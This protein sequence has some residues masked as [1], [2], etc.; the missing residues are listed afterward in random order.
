MSALHWTAVSHGALH[1]AW[2]HSSKPK[3]AIRPVAGTRRLTCFRRLHLAMAQSARPRTPSGASCRPRVLDRT[4]PPPSSQPARA[5]HA[6]PGSGL[7]GPAPLSR[8]LIGAEPA[9]PCP[10]RRGLLCD[11][12]CAR[13]W[14][15]RPAPPPARAVVRLGR[16]ASELVRSKG[17]R[18]MAAAGLRGGLRGALVMQ[19]R[20]WSSGSGSDQLGELGSGA[21]KGGG[22]GGSIREA[23]G[24]FGKRQAAH[25]ERY[26]RDKERE[27]LASLREH[28]E[29]EIDHHKKEI[30]RL[31][32]EIERHKI[33]IKKLKD[34]QYKV[35]QL[36]ISTAPREFTT[37]LAVMAAHLKN[38]WNTGSHS[39]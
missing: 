29:E 14:L 13:R 10:F 4:A 25:E 36:R 26:F 33:K 23:G 22:G 19:Q 2:T 37:C 3:G 17:R 32:K 20:G 16:S 31:Q 24:A 12:P 34:N 9:P 35:L 8:T 27:Q 38:L 28:H 21:G 5:T 7:V 18:V 11:S 6:L 15:A 30:Q 39:K 1:E